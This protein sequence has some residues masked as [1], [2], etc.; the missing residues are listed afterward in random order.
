LGGGI[1]S[2]GLSYFTGQELRIEPGAAAD[3]GQAT[4]LALRLAG[5]LIYQGRLETTEQATA[6]NGATLRLEPSSNGRF[7][8]VWAG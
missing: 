2:R 4:L 8:R 5:Q 1:E 3:E 7:V 6:P